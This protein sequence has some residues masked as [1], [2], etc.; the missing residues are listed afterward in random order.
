MHGEGKMRG[1][2]APIEKTY[3]IRLQSISCRKFLFLKR[4]LIIQRV[5]VDFAV[6]ILRNIV[7]C[8]NTPRLRSRSAAFA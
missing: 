3:F 4:V 8:G 1:S 7:D 5:C 6:A 2:S